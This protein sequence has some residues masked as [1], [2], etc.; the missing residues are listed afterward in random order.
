MGAGSSTDSTAASELANSLLTKLFTQT[1]MLSYLT[2]TDPKACANFDFSSVNPA[3]QQNI[4][5]AGGQVRILG[6]QAD[7]TAVC[8]EQAKGYSKC[9]ELYAALYPLLADGSVKRS[10]IV[11]KGGRR[12]RRQR[13]GGELVSGRKEYT[14]ITSTPLMALFLIK[15]TFYITHNDNY[16]Q[17]DISLYLSEKINAVTFS[18]KDSD[19][20]SDTIRVKGQA[21][22][23]IGSGAEKVECD[24]ELTKVETDRYEFSINNKKVLVLQFNNGR[25]YYYEVMDG[26]ASENPIELGPRIKAKLSP[27]LIQSIKESIGFTGQPSSGSASTSG[28]ATAASVS[29]S[30][31]GAFFP[32]TVGEVKKNLQNFKDTKKNKPIALAIARA[33][34]LLRPLDPANSTGRAPTT[35]ICAKTFTFEGK[36][37]HVPRKGVALDKTYYFKSW[38]NLYADTGEMRAGKYEWVKGAEG[39]QELNLAAEDLSILYSQPTRDPKF[40][41]KPLPEFIT[42]CKKYEGEYYI[43]PKVIPQIQ[44][45]VQQLMNVQ[46]THVGYANDILKKVF[47]FKSDGTVAFR[48]EI[49]GREGYARLSELCKQTRHMLFQYYMSVESLFIQGVMIYEQALAT[50]LLRPV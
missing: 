45:V 39:M 14:Q 12:T 29:V 19:V 7:R 47:D 30:V 43:D 5:A 18:I 2:M 11:M 24:I 49:L 28:S 3:M 35:Q 13:G 46:K 44:K 38:M 40:L 42:L 27:K 33:L 21:N 16:P 41:S 8:F 48:K 1:D 22:R 34:M 23:G 17:Y 31:T 25:W 6:G 15:E 20:A 4:R 9:F 26:V 50:N 36:D 37:S 10:G 32:P